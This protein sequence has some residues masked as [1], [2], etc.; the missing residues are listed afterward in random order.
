MKNLLTALALVAATV[1]RAGDAPA[2]DL[3]KK[4]SYPKDWIPGKTS[5]PLVQVSQQQVLNSANPLYCS[6]TWVFVDGCTFTIKNFT[7][8]NAYQSQW[9]G[10]VVGLVNGVPQENKN[11]VNMVKNVVPAS[12][13]QDATFNLITTAGASYSFFSV[14]QLRL[15]DTL[16]NQ[17][18]CTVDL[19]YNNPNVPGSSTGSTTG[20]TAGTGAT[21]TKAGSDASSSVVGLLGLAVA[22]LFV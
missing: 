8:L 21:T 2:V 7:F 18:I 6:G 15:F 13:L 5:A 11:A 16:Q 9:Y 17:V 20:S 19:P 3:C 4:D 14:N 12:N 10:G 22:A 1:V